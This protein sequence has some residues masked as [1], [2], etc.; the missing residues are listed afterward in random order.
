MQIIRSE[1]L[2]FFLTNGVVISLLLVNYVKISREISVKFPWTVQW[3]WNS[4]EFNTFEYPFEIEVTQS[5]LLQTRGF[6]LV[7]FCCYDFH[8]YCLESSRGARHRSLGA[9]LPAITD[10][11]LFKTL[12]FYWFLLVPIIKKTKSF[13]SLE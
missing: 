13:S 1:Y 6:Y 12:Y 2:I 11:L 5:V 10:T 3:E 7:P 9:T 4:L 8:S